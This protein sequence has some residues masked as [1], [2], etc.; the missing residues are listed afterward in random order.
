MDELVKKLSSG[1][2]PVVFEPRIEKAHDVKERINQGFVFVKFT[3]TQGGT[4]LGITLDNSLSCF[5]NADFEIGQGTIQIVG[6]CELNF[7]KVRCFADI[8]LA[9]RVGIGHL[10]PLTDTEINL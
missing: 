7:Q 9:T 5:K 2:H 1:S 8:D 4:E 6:T 3:E 10:E